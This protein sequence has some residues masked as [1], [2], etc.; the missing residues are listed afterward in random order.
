MMALEMYRLI[1]SY[2]SP[3][4]LVCSMHVQEDIHCHVW[5]GGVNL[6]RCMHGSVYPEARVCVPYDPLMDILGHRGT[7][8]GTK[9]ATGKSEEL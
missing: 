1:A 5:P 4:D 9:E 8:E 3:P 2:F 6:M 7:A